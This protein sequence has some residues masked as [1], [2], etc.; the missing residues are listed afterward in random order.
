[1]LLV[2]LLRILDASPATFETPLDAR[3]EDDHPDA[4]GQSGKEAN[5][6][7]KDN[8]PTTHDDKSSQDCNKRKEMFGIFLTGK[9]ALQAV[10]FWHVT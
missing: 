6:E 2:V 8:P 10:F 4:E 7:E 1:M 9:T 5:V 3:R